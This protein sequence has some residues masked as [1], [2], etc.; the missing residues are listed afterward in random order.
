[1]G[2]DLAR[3][4]DA[5]RAFHAQPALDVAKDLDTDPKVGLNPDEAARRLVRYGHNTLTLRRRQSPFVR[6]LLQFHQPL[7]YILLISAAVTFYMGDTVDASVIFGVVLVNAIVG[8][9]Q[10][11]K[12]VTAI[13]ALSKTMQAEATV[14]RAGQTHRVSQTV[15][16]PGDV[17][18][19]QSGDKV[20]ADLRLLHVHELQV[21]ESALTGESV[22]VSKN[23]AP[24]EPDTLLPER[25]NMAFASTLVTHGQARGVVV[26]TGDQ[27]QIGAISGL[28]SEAEDLDTPLTQRIARFSRVLTVV[29]LVFAAVAI[30]V[31][32]YIREQSWMDAFSA[33]VALVVGAIPEG[34]PAAMTIILAIGISRMAQR[35]AI[36]RKLPAVETLGSTSVICSDKTGTLTENQ[37]T[38]RHVVAGDGSYDVTGT[39]YAPEG[40]FFLGRQSIDSNQA[41]DAL[42]ELLRCG[43]GCNDALVVEKEGRWVV[44]GDPTEGAMVVAA[45]KLRQIKDDISNVIPRMDVIPFESERGYMATLH[46]QGPNAPTVVYL[47]GG[48]EKILERCSDKLGP[49]GPEPLDRDAIMQLAANLSRTGE[50]V[51]GFARKHLPTG[52]REIEHAHVAGE[53]TFLGLQAMLDPPRPEAFE[54][55]A[56]CHR[57]GIAVKMITGDHALTAS[58]IAKEIGLQGELAADGTLVAMTGRQLE[59]QSET[60]LSDVARRVGVFARV[61][62]EQKLRLVRVLQRQNQVV[63]MTGD[64]V[65]DAPALRQANIGVAM[66]LAGTE[67]AKEAADMVLTD[68]NFASI[69]AAVEEGRG[70]FDNLT[71]FLAWT[72]PTNLGEGLVILLAIALGTELPISPVQILW[73][74][75]TTGILLGMMLAF[76]PREKDA[77][78][79]P[80]RDPHAP[81]LGFPLV[82]RMC[83]IALLMVV[84]AFGL[85]EWMRYRGADLHQ[86][87]TV[88]VN[89]FVFVGIFYMFNSRSLQHSSFHIGFFSNKPLLWGVA[90]MIGLQLFFTYAP[91]MHRLFHSAPIGAL[92]WLLIVGSGLLASLVIGAE[93]WLRRRMGR[94]IGMCR[95]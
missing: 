31:A 5:A 39:G 4:K 6:F 12:A 77:M 94:A 22:S 40:Q 91:I 93:K 72:L 43:V 59:S 44:I 92:E 10:E 15:I 20:P 88:A 50:R 34:L 1:M 79:R 23:T 63:A 51:L 35:R 16:V 73:I 60:S 26:A 67:V 95:V 82:M 65:N 57:A 55:V 64:G 25:N 33:A 37:M 61:T 41:P 76:E 42:V 8:F 71:K 68:D 17:V 75:M 58:A 29:I 84:S 2:M 85:F 54:A 46:S 70:V 81:I 24:V 32:V 47:K 11:S 80:P 53:M 48:V 38:V 86:S 90:L 45:A 30:V 66:G 14:L 52:T 56:A 28:I 27:T 36:I 83:L 74:N 69:R 89:V 18:L 62:P 3:Q 78:S 9:V 7:I 87:T 21:D 49:T 19:L 13:D